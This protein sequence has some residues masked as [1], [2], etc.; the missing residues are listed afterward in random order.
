MPLAY[1]HQILS[2][3]ARNSAPDCICKQCQGAL[4]IG[5]NAARSRYARVFGKDSLG[6][7]HPQSCRRAALPK[8]LHRSSPHARDPMGCIASSFLAAGQHLADFARMFFSQKSPRRVSFQEGFS[9][10]LEAFAAVINEILQLRIPQIGCFFST[11]PISAH[12]F[13]GYPATEHLGV[14]VPSYCTLLRPARLAESGLL[15]SF[16][17]RVV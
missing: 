14:G 16:R 5:R 10:V 15:G 17:T 3:N 1:A 2:E 11:A 8:I 7:S 9:Q 6:S 4:A 12:Q 13:R